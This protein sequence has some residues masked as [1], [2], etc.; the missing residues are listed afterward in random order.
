MRRVVRRRWQKLRR[1]IRDVEKEKKALKADTRKALTKA[2]N[3]LAKAE[4]EKQKE[5]QKRIRAE[6]HAVELSNSTEH[7]SHRVVRSL[8]KLADADADVNRNVRTT[9]RTTSAIT[10]APADPPPNGL[11]AAAVCKRDSTADLATMIVK[12]VKASTMA[13]IRALVANDGA[14][15]EEGEALLAKRRR[16][17]EPVRSRFAR[18]ASS[19]SAGLCVWTEIDETLPFADFLNGFRNEFTIRFVC[20]LNLVEALSSLSFGSSDSVRSTTDLSS[21][22]DETRRISGEPETELPTTP[23]SPAANDDMAP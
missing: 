21:A 23:S 22:L 9:H 11:L 12:F 17:N 20:T 6:C 1:R 4:E 15:R 14:R 19:Y 2:E 8:D 7:C 13:E 3:M 18:T 16:E 10:A 5:V